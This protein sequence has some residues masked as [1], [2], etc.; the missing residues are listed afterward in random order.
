MARKIQI[1]TQI[2][3]DLLKKYAIDLIY[4]S[5]KKKLMATNNALAT[6]SL[7]NIVKKEQRYKVKVGTLLSLKF[8]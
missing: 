1:K 6:C 5:M 4:I 7:L 8:K 3:V 2:S